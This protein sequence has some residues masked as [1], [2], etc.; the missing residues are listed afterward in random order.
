MTEEEKA[1]MAKNTL[2]AAS[3]G[4]DKL[5]DWIIA[6]QEAVMEAFEAGKEKREVSP[7]ATIGLEAY[8]K[9]KAEEKRLIEEEKMDPAA[10]KAAGEA[11]T[12]KLKAEATAMVG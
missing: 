9:G 6:N 5:A 3:E 12:A 8:R 11:L 10:A 4:D 1:V 2:V 7:Q